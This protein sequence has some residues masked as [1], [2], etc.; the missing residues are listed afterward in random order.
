MYRPSSGGYALD[1][2]VSSCVSEDW[3]GKIRCA[4]R[5]AAYALAGG[6]ENRVAHRR[7]NRRDGRFA[8]TARRI[9]RFEDVNLH[10]RH[11][12]DSKQLVIVEIALLI[13]QDRRR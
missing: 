7:S 2:T 5:Q 13:P 10:N 6:S 3:S 1:S 12:V 8:D 11:F 4:N 9:F